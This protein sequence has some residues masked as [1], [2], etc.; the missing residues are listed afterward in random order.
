MNNINNILGT[1]IDQQR[2]DYLQYCLCTKRLSQN[3]V[4]AYDIDLNQFLIFLEQEYPEITAGE[5]VLKPVLQDYLLDLNEKYA[6]SSTKRKIACLKGFFNWMIEEELIT[7]HPFTHLRIRMREPQRLPNVMSLKEVSKVLKAAYN[8]EKAT[9]DFLYWRDIAVLEILFATGLRVHELC[10][11]K[12]SDYNARQNSFRIVGKGNKERYVFITNP[13][14][15]SAFHNY[16]RMV[17]KYH[18]KN[19]YIFLTKYSKQLST[20]AVRNLVT[21]YTKLAGIKRTITPHAFRHSFAT[22]LLEE[23]VD[24]K[25]IQEFLGHSSI[26]T[27]QIYLHVTAASSK[28]I[29]KNKHPRKKMNMTEK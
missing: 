16:Q 21:K 3:S 20:Q 6:V 18:I 23:G 11:L 19:E 25:Y 17:K 28:K 10:N 29:L 2:E 13:E 14:T 24:I 27:T 8:D 4:S 7:E 9:S 1:K 26:T 12:Y 22:L 15:L 5:Q